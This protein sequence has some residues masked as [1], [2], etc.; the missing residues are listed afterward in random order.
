[1][2]INTGEYVHIIHRWLFREDAQHHFVETVKSHEG[3]IMRVKG[4]RQG[5]AAHGA[6]A[7]L[8]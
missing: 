1:M 2:T 6:A 8:F 5:H 4:D 3:T 7:S